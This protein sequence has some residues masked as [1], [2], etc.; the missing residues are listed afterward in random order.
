M[1]ILLL[2]IFFGDDYLPSIIAEASAVSGEMDRVRA[3]IE[4]FFDKEDD[5][6]RRNFSGRVF[7]DLSAPS[8]CHRAVFRGYGFR[9]GNHTC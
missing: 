7:V 6:V 9:I 1:H 3:I 4:W 5:N 2:E 8:K